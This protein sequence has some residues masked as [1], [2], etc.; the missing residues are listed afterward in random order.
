MKATKVNSPAKSN[1]L[2]K[3]RM[4]KHFLR[5]WQLH[6]LI[7]LPVI[8]M[9]IFHYAPMYGAQI[10]FRNYKAKGGLTGSEWV[11][12]KNFM[13]F[14]SSS[15]A[16]EIVYN[17]LCISLYQICVGFPLPVFFALMINTVRKEKFKKFVQNIAYMPHFISTVVLVA[18]VDMCLSPI[19]GI[20]GT[21]YRTITGTFSYPTDIRPIAS[22]F[23][24]L[25]VWSGIWQTLGWSTIVYTAALSG[26]SQELHEAAMLDGA[27]RWQRVLNVD[28]PSILPTVCTMLI[29]R[30]GSIMGVGFEKVYLMQTPLNQS[31]SE[32]ISTFV[33]KQGMQKAGNY[34]Y[35]SAIGLM[36]SLVNS[37]MLLAVNWVTKKLSDGD[38]GLF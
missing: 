14:L 5:D 30:F 11:G 18:I 36:N 13:K 26:V 29:M 35:A 2:M 21:I 34:S 20:Y 17:T 3:S 24:H 12:L 6:L 38:Y 27:S 1:P 4:I 15:K 19:N 16:G 22:S 25:Y 7:L 33:Y 28:F 32:V 8:Y 31:V 9:I 10:A 23:R 37:A